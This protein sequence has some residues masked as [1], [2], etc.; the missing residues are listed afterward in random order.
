MKSELLRLYDDHLR[1]DAALP[2]MTAQKLPEVTRYADPA[3]RE[4]LIMWHSFAEENSE[5][6]VAR[7]FKSFAKPLDAFTWKVYANDEPRG[8]PRLLEKS[9]MKVERLSSLMVCEASKAAELPRANA[10]SIRALKGPDEIHELNDVWE[11]VWPGKNG[12][13]V[14]IL[15]EAMT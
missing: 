14:A 10:I 1:R 11:S 6:I 9:G 15:G 8:L 12:A 5:E 3:G 2:G 7:E 13:W 4:G